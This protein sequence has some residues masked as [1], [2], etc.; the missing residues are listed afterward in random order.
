MKFTARLTTI[1]GGLAVAIAFVLIGALPTLS[2]SR[3]LRAQGYSN[4]IPTISSGFGTAPSVTAGTVGSFRVNVGTG[5]AATG[6]V[7]ATNIAAPTGWNC[8]VNDLTAAAANVA[9]FTDRQTASTTTTITIQHQTLSTGAALVY[10]AS[11]IV[12]LLCTPF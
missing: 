1:L 6:G 9:A 3:T 4:A 12:Q 2:V 10:T 7:I 5:G 11:D 8:S